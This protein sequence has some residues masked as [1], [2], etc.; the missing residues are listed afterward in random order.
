[1]YAS[2]AQ[3]NVITL[4]GILTLLVCLCFTVFLCEQKTASH[5]ESLLDLA[6]PSD[7]LTRPRKACNAVA[8]RSERLDFLDC[9]LVR[10]ENGMTAHG[11]YVHL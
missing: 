9:S 11:P 10:R 2:S 5:R 1:M 4:L 8:S 6:V 3:W 7:P